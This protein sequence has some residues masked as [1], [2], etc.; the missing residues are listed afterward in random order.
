MYVK[1]SCLSLWT[2]WM[3]PKSLKSRPRRES[4]IGARVDHLLDFFEGR[5][6]QATDK[7]CEECYFVQQQLACLSSLSAS[8]YL[9]LSSHIHPP[10][11]T[12]Y[13]RVM[14]FITPTTTTFG[15]G[16]FSRPNSRGHS[17]LAS[18]RGFQYH[19]NSKG[20]DVSM[21]HQCTIQ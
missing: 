12:M 1:M 20:N 2:L 15:V 5:T 19:T 9:C 11:C 10:S 17:V 4:S 13:S 14:S 6:V 8:T 21:R 18:V 3:A 16:I 7:H